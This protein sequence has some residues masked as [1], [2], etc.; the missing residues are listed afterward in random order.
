MAI[1]K[2]DISYASDEN[3]FYQTVELDGR[4][5]QLRFTWNQ[6]DAAWRLSVYQPDGTPLANSRKI[7]LNIPLLRGEIDERLPLGWI[8]AYDFTGS[9]VEAAHDDL[10]ERVLL[11]YYDADFIATGQ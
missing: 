4:R 5:Y 8:V 11:I 7:V 1:W 3:D 2:I 9:N 6:R 10:G